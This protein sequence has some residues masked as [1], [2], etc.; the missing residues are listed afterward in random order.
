MTMPFEKAR[1]L[2][3][4]CATMINVHRVLVGSGKLFRDCPFIIDQPRRS[5]LTLIGCYVYSTHNN[6][7]CNG[8]GSVPKNHF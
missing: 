6:E 1:V 7:D 4:M 5:T 2:P 8:G 3:C